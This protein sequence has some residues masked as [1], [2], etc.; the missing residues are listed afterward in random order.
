MSKIKPQDKVYGIF[1]L[2]TNKWL[3][4]WEDE[5]EKRIV[6]RSQPVAEKYYL[7][8]CDALANGEDTDPWNIETREDTRKPNDLILPDVLSAALALRK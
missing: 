3:T 7:E 2:N 4:T 6:W 1:I 8:M 5:T